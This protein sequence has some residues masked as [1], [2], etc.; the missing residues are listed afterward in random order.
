MSEGTVAAYAS[1]ARQ[2]GSTRMASDRRPYLNSKYRWAARVPQAN[3]RE[4]SYM[5]EKG[6]CPAAIQRKPSAP[7]KKTNALM[8]R[9]V[10]HLAREAVTRGAGWS[11]ETSAS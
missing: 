7:V 6:P 3:E 5:L 2:T 1:M 11:D 9:M 8:V 10:P 4:N